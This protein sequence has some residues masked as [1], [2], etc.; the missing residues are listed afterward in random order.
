MN[1][2]ET[3]KTP[4]EFTT[5]LHLSELTGLKA[6]T[7]QQMIALIET[8]PGSCIYYH[9]HRFLQQHQWLSPEP[10]NDFSYWIKKALG[11]DE[12]SEKV[13]SIDT[14]QFV[15]IRG[16]R[17][18]LARTMRVYADAHP[19]IKRKKTSKG[20]EFNFIKAVSFVVKTP[21]RAF[22]LEEFEE[23]LSKITIDCIYYHVFEARL[24]LERKSNDFSCW[25]EDSCGNA[26]LAAEIARLDPYTQTLEDLRASIIS[27]VREHIGK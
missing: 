3:A 6:S 24:R 21:Y 13:A 17:D 5:R 27:L 11:E 2:C 1:S 14:V 15:N 8:V 26:I 10:P 22:S 25:I 12:L 7:V 23:I 20:D 9:T 4:F 19:G 16:L 18:E